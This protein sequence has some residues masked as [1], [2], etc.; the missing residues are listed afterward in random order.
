MNKIDINKLNFESI[1]FNE[2][3]GYTIYYLIDVADV[4]KEISTKYVG[5]DKFTLSVEVFCDELIVQISPA[6]LLP[7]DIWVDYNYEDYTGFEEKE[8]EDLLALTQKQINKR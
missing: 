5:F 7:D 6:K 2:T 4:P 8:I 1:H 3:H